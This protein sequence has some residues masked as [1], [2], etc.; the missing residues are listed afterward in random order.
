MAALEGKQTVED[1][2]A[3]LS[4]DELVATGAH[5]FLLMGNFPERRLTLQP[6]KM[7]YLIIGSIP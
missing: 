1:E 6:T 5:Q 4:A 2:I 7:S 3:S